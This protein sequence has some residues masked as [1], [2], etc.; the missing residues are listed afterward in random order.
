MRSLWNA[1]YEA[2]G[3]LW[4]AEPNQFLV[5]IADVLEPGTALDLGC[6]QGRNSFWLASRGF[7]VTG[8]DLSPVAIEQARGVAEEFDLDVSF[9]S[10]DLTRWDPA[11]RVWDL[12]GR[13]RMRLVGEH[14]RTATF[15]PDGSSILTTSGNGFARLWPAAVVDL[16][17]Q[18]DQVLA[19]TGRAFSAEEIARYQRLL[20][21]E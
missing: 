5:E 6:G 11:A 2:E 10:V 13:E 15:S 12:D 9:E 4:G 3:S 8:L 18:T 20:D 19:S 1:R 17:E 7:T 16:L 14:F 21:V